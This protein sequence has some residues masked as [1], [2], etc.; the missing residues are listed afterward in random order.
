[1]QGADGK[2][3]LQALDPADQEAFERLQEAQQNKLS[4]PYVSQRPAILEGGQD[5]SDLLL[6]NQRGGIDNTRYYNDNV[7]EPAKDSSTRRAISEYDAN[8]AAQTRAFQ[9]M[10]EGGLA[11]RNRQLD[12]RA[13]GRDAYI[14]YARG[15]DTKDLITKL[16]IGAGL[17]FS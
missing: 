17:M 5:L 10:Q 4:Q 15:A 2:P 1:V 6:N 11:L 3:K 16:L 8:I 14:D 9:E 7:L 13:S 12:D